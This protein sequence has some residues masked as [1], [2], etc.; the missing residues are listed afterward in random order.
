M[1]GISVTTLMWA[2]LG[3]IVPTFLW[4][5]FWLS[6][7][8]HQNPPGLL[9]LA[10]AA[11]MGALFII[12]PMKMFVESFPFHPTEALIIYVILEEL[13]K[14]GLV[15]VVVFPTK[16]L[17]DPIDYTIYLVTGALG[18]SGLENTL[19]LLNPVI[20]N[21]VAQ[22]LVTGNL[23][24][25]GATVLH[26]VTAGILGIA[27][28]I[29]FYRGAFAKTLHLVFGL[30]FAIGL[31]SVFNYLILSETTRLTN[32]AILGVWFVAITVFIVFRRLKALQVYL[33]PYYASPA[34]TYYDHT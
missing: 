24:F 20:A 7:E 8:T 6:E 13:I 15:A 2:T 18:F 30:F 32:L 27:L 16:F 3:G 22:T 31:H 29:A 23:R 14:F 26:T 9:F 33:R 10:Y 5:W 12:M 21:N 1:A 17:S 19:Y 28:G 4:L 11:G 25:L 34:H